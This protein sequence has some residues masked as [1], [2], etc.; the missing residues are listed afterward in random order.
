ME[1]SENGEKYSNYYKWETSKQTPYN[2]KKHGLLKHVMSSSIVNTD[3]EIT[4]Y[5]L[6]YIETSMTILMSYVDRLKN[7]KNYHWKN[8]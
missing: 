1:Y 6:M 3:N 8:R 4:Q 2:Y 5:I 7:F